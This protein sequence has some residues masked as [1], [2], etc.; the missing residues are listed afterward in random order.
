ME[1]IKLNDIKPADYNPRAITE[2]SAETLVQSIELLGQIKPILVNAEN[3]TIIAGHQR[4]NALQKLGYTDC[5][6]YILKGLKSG[7]EMRFNQLHN[8]CECEVSEKAP[9]IIINQKLSKGLQEIKYNWL[10]IIDYGKISFYVTELAKLTLKFGLFAAPII[11]TNGEIIVSSAYAMAC[12]YIK[13]DFEA[14]VVADDLK[15]KI[16]DFFSKGYGEFSYDHIERKT[17]VQ[18]YAQLTRLSKIEG[19]RQNYS[20]LYEKMVIPYLITQPNQGKGLNILDFGAGKYAYA[21]RLQTEGH[22]IDF[23]DPYHRKGS[24]DYIDISDN[25]KN[26]TQLSTI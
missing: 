8:M 16:I 1:R 14:F 25:K 17:Y 9:R 24:S 12:F 19:K 10:N 21:K 2:E 20:T 4:T 5:Y 22:I 15:A 6:G 7:D 18:G 11:T 3:N 26:I 23:V 13:R